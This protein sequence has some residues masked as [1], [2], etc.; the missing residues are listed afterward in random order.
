MA[1]GRSKIDAVVVNERDNVAVALRDIKPCEKILVSIK[2]KTLELIVKDFIRRGH[3]IALYDIKRGEYII[4]Y[5]EV[6]GVAT[7]D[8]ERGRH[9]HCHNVKSA[10][11]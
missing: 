11:V 10:R 6:I 5:G 2:D 4:K 9:V 3:K 8:I 7:E 1:S